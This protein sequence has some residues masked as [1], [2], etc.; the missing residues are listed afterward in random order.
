MVYI[1]VVFLNNPLFIDFFFLLY[2]LS[3]DLS[4]IAQLD[5]KKEVKYDEN[6]EVKLKFQALLKNYLM[7]R[8]ND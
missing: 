3:N 7:E 8:Q 4:L 5:F 2:I 6:F 1:T